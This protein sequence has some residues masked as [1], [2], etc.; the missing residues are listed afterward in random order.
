MQVLVIARVIPGTPMEQVLPLVKAEA[1]KVWD[2]YAS[3]MVRSVYYIADMSGAVLLLEAP[4][5]EAANE[6]VA[7]F[8]MVQANVLK[9]EILPLK[10]YTGIAELFAK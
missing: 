9:C 3:E 5:I 6:A 8:P 2:Y 4:S 10:P 7:Q 1:A